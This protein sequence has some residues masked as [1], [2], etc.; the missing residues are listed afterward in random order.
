MRENGAVVLLHAGLHGLY[1]QISPRSCDPGGHQ[2]RPQREGRL[3]V[4]DHELQWQQQIS[5]CHLF[6]VREGRE[7][8]CRIFLI[9]FYLFSPGTPVPGLIPEGTET[10]VEIPSDPNSLKGFSRSISTDISLVGCQLSRQTVSTIKFHQWCSRGITLLLR[11]PFDWVWP[12][13]AQETRTVPRAL[14]AASTAAPTAASSP[15]SRSTSH[16][17]RRRRGPSW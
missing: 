5:L 2:V 1:T 17:S 11:R 3:H 14:A 9:L 15:G 16:R 8:L 4:H 10:P 13:G 12:P 7:K 6:Q